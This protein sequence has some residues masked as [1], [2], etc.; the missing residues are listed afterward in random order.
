MKTYADESCRAEIRRRLR[1][2]HAQSV[3]QWGRMSAHQMICHLS[4][5]CR[6]AL[7]E[8]HVSVASGPLPRTL[9]K[10]FALYLPVRW[11]PG[12]LT[13][14]EIDQLT[15]GTSPGTFA[16]DV[17]QLEALLDRM[18]AR[19]RHSAWPAHPLFGRMSGAAWLR[20]AYLHA[21]H[22]LRQFGA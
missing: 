4:D 21:D 19:G 6:M 15:A 20:W 13:R 5:A 14:P 7:G 8:K 2:V 12:I 22:H 9:W 16:D 17:E 3:R 1:T 10:W 18:A 11:P